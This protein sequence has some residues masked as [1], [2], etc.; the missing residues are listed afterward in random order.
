MNFL[1]S[2]VIAIFPVKNSGNCVVFP[3]FLRKKRDIFVSL[4]LSV[5]EETEK[6]EM[7]R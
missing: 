2:I 6:L 4:F 3:G 7:I 1:E 5:K